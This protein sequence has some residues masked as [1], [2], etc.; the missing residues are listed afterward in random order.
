LIDFLDSNP[1]SPIEA[2]LPDRAAMPQR[3]LKKM[4]RS[5]TEYRGHGFWSRDVQLE[6]W[7]RLL[8]LNL[9][10]ALV[11]GWQKDLQHEW[12]FWSSGRCNGFV[13]AQL[14][15]LSDDPEKVVTV[16][17]TSRKTLDLISACGECIPS[18]FLNLLGASGRFEQAFSTR[19]IVD[20]GEQFI[21]LLENKDSEL[22]EGGKASPA[23]S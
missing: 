10:D 7:L 23:T 16:L 20:V 9:P 12:F 14:D 4:G 21:A 19:L 18:T 15:T 2:A 1:Y 8:A 17:R 5:Y 6:L 22:C 11:P 3:S 13:S